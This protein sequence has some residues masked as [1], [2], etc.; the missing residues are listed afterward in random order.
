[1]GMIRIRTVLQELISSRSQS[2]LKYKWMATQGG[3]MATAR[4]SSR[5]AATRSRTK[6]RSSKRTANKISLT[7]ALYEL[8]TMTF[9][10]RVLI[11]TLIGLGLIG[12]NLLISKNRYEVFYVLCGVELI[13]AIAIAWLKLLIK[14]ET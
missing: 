7:G 3:I 14:P 5:T 10:G 4:K 1:M 12:I 2:D 8:M 11:V 9:F 6:S 13:A